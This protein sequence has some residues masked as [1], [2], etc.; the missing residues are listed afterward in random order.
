[1]LERPDA[2]NLYWALT[3]LPRPFLDLRKPVE[4]EFGTVYR[5]FPQLRDLRKQKLTTE[6][7]QVVL[8]DLLQ[9]IVKF[10]GMA[11]PGQAGSPPPVVEKLGVAALVIKLYP[12]AKK[13]LVAGG[14][15][16]EQVEA[17]PSVQV[18]GI[19][20]LDQYDHDRD[21]VLKWFGLPSWQARSGLE[22]E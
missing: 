10:E 2:P 22:Q 14:R 7:A 15:T 17:M 19:Y 6:Q 16:R 12:E 18:V 21:E 11:R 5:S 20:L 13:Y 1:L 4:M 9:E 8:D 3:S